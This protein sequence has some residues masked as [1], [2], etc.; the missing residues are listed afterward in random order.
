MSPFAQLQCFFF[1][2]RDVTRKPWFG[3]CGLGSVCSRL[4]PT[5]QISTVSGQCVSGR[6]HVCSVGQ[7][8][9]DSISEV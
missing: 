8:A 7:C 6:G 3:T 5:I 9:V 2:T 4:K 1:L